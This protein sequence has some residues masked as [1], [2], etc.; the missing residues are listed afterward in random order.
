MCKKATGASYPAI[1]NSDILDYKIPDAPIK[2]MEEFARFA[3]QADKSGFTPVLLAASLQ[4]CD[5]F[6]I[7]IPV[8]IA[9]YF[10]KATIA[11]PNIP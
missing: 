4:D 3:E 7:S 11:S 1:K 5:A 10:N 2:E 8:N 9:R 6:L